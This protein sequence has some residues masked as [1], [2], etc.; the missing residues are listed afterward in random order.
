MCEKYNKI[1]VF[2]PITQDSKRLTYTHMHIYYIHTPQ[3]FAYLIM[4]DKL[5]QILLSKLP[6]GTVQGN[7]R[8]TQVEQRNNNAICKF[9]DGSSEEFD[10]VIG[11]DGINSVVRQHV[12]GVESPPVYSGIR[13][14][15]Y[16]VCA[17]NR[18]IRCVFYE[19]CV[20]NRGIRCVFY[21]V[22]ALNIGIRCVFHVRLNFCAWIC[23]FVW[24]LDTLHRLGMES[25]A[26][27]LVLGMNTMKPAWVY[28]VLSNMHVYVCVCMSPFGTVRHEST[29]TRT[30]TDTCSLW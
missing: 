3:V 14:V 8:L 21:E 15:F 4:R 24:F 29:Y 28:A 30:L 2:S 5:N 22:C 10:L 17:L 27:C 26:L 9:S 25:L 12:V 20:L 18:G 6:A 23:I 1:G 19:L 11:C 16:E 7:K 13:C